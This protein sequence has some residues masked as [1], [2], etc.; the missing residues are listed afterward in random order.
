MKFQIFKRWSSELK[1]E[2]EIG[3]EFESQPV[4]IQ[5]GAAIKAALAAD[6]DLRGSDLRGSDL[7]GSDLRDSD[8]SDSDLRGSDLSDSDLSGSDLRGSDLSDSDLR[9]S[10]LRDSDLSGSDLRDFVVPSLH[11]KILAAIEAG[12][13]FDMSKWHGG[14]GVCGTTH[15]R[16]GW[17]IHL[18]GPVGRTLEYCLGSNAAGALIHL[19]SCP[20]LEGKVPNFIDTNEN[21]LADIKRLAELEPPLE[22]VNG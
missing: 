12:G 22:T 13:T 8:L 6:S 10:D 1:L 9:G 18:A 21:A 20:Q 15:C 16:A 5:R 17:A 4:S 19:A 2:I 11:R 3:A 7:R 14:E